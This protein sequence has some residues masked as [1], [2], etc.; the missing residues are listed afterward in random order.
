MEDLVGC[1]NVKDKVAFLEKPKCIHAPPKM[2]SSPSHV[3]FAFSLNKCGH[4]HVGVGVTTYQDSLI[5]KSSTKLSVI[6]N[7]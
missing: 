2:E 6:E 7:R 3:K 1:W 5:S 4:L